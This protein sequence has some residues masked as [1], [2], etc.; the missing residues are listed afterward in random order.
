V[1]DRLTARLLKCDAHVGGIGIVDQE[2]QA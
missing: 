1:G 2:T